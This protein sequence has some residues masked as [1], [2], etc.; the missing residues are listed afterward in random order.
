MTA[1]NSEQ[2]PELRAVAVQQLGNMGAHEE[3]WA[4]YQ[5][6]SSVDMKKG[7]IRALFV[8]GSSTRLSELAAA[9]RTRSCGFSRSATSA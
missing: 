6:E 7:I 2:N 1:A 9:S 3:L 5:K 8:G 4:L